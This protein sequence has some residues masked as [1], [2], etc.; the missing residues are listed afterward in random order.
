MAAR[1]LIRHQNDVP[2]LVAAIKSGAN[3][4]L[5]NNREHFTEEVARRTGLRIASPYEFFAA[6]HA[7]A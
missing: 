6:V 3:W 7:S 4:L 2:V 5:T 1:H